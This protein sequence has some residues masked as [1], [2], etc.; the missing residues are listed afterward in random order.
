MGEIRSSPPPIE[1]QPQPRSRPGTMEKGC[2][3]AGPAPVRPTRFVTPRT[4]GP[5]PTGR[6]VTK[7]SVRTRQNRSLLPDSSRGLRPRGLRRDKAM[8]EEASVLSGIEPML[9]VSARL[10]GGDHLLGHRDLAAVARISSGACVARLTA[11]TP[12]PRSST[13]SPRASAVVIVS[14][15]ALTIFSTSRWYRC[16]FWPRSSQSVQT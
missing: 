5:L 15:M 4:E 3:R 2:R 1:P 9:H 14:K 16:G 12:K 11:N 10:E 6:A 8:D 13:R 7:I